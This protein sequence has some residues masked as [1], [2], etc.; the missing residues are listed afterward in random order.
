M[1]NIRWLVLGYILGIA[2]ALNVNGEF[3]MGT[4][5]CLFGILYLDFFNEKRK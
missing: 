1:K 3:F 5:A 4:I 2:I